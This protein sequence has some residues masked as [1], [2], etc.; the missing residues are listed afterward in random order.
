MKL[1]AYLEQN[2]LDAEAFAALISR[3]PITVARYLNG[4]RM[5]RK[6]EMALIHEATAGAVQPN[7]F[8]ELPSY[9][10]LAGCNSSPERGA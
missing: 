1:A 5:P 2:G 3:K 8:Y 10:H 6:A 4:T 7:D 9:A